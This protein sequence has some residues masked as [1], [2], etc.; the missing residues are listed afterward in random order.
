LRARCGILVSRSMTPLKSQ[1]S[2]KYPGRA[3]VL[4]PASARQSTGKVSK[5]AVSNCKKIDLYT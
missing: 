2:L 3:V 1:K 4:C 5:A